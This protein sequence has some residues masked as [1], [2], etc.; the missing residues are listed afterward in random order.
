MALRLDGVANRAND[1][2]VGV[3]R[4]PIGHVFG[5]GLSGDGGNGAVDVASGNQHLKDGRGATDLVQVLHVVTTGRSHIGQEGGLGRHAVDV[6]ECKVDVGR[7]SH[8][9]VMKDAVGGAAQDH[10][11]DESVLERL[12]GEKIARTDVLLHAD[13]DVLRS[14]LALP[15]LLRTR[16]RERRR[17]W[18]CKTHGLNSSGHGVG[19][20][21]TAAGAGARAS[22]LL[23]VVH[24]IGGGGL[25]VGAGRLET[26]VGVS[27]RCLVAGD[28]VD[29]LVEKLRMATAH[30][31]AIDHDERAVVTSCSHDDAGHILVATR[32]GDVGIMMLS[33]SH[34]LDGV[35]DDF[36]TLEGVAHA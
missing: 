10:G 7:V 13:A 22:M 9:E 32:D 1:L 3:Q 34:G 16:G 4:R 29:G 28:D 14:L 2:L 35:G 20:I 36:A 31:A 12:L 11:Q 25:R 24:D 21:H 26:T 18:S 27:T 23:D 30:G 15:E 6:V 19:G 17:A 8:G 33:T 5:E